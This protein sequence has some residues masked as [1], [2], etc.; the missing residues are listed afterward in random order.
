MANSK[1]AIGTLGS[2]YF[3]ASSRMQVET[4]FKLCGT[5]LRAPQIS[6]RRRYGTDDQGPNALTSRRDFLRIAGLGAMAMGLDVSDAGGSEASAARDSAKSGG[7][8]HT[9]EPM[10]WFTNVVP[11]FISG[12]RT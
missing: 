2:R 3:P 10:R 12:N 8:V 7:G 5:E 6:R 4:Q 11:R 1:A 9:H